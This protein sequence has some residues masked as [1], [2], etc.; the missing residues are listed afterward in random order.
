MIW[1]LKKSWRRLRWAVFQA[2]RNRNRKKNRSQKK[3]MKIRC[4]KKMRT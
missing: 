1:T 4:Q 2:R 3:R